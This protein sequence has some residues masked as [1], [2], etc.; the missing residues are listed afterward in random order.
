MHSQFMIQRAL[1]PS[2]I[3]YLSEIVC[4]EWP[5]PILRTFK[6]EGH[7][8]FE[9]SYT[10]RQIAQGPS[11]I[12]NNYRDLIGWFAIA[13]FNQ[14]FKHLPTNELKGVWLMIRENEGSKK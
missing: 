8:P 12:E 14:Y 9:G 3:R 2:Q 1:T 4:D 5:E 6:R 7:I 10:E 11:H 13:F